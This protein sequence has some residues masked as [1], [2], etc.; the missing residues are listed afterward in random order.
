M[1]LFKKKDLEHPD[2]DWSRNVVLEEGNIDLLF[3]PRANLIYDSVARV[4]S[5]SDVRHVEDS[6]ELSTREILSR[7]ESNG[8]LYKLKLGNGAH[9]HN[10]AMINASLISAQVPDRYKER[11]D[12]SMDA[13]KSIEML[14][15]YNQAVENSK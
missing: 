1:R 6:E 2:S 3:P 14:N 11:A 8:Q 5:G 12:I 4:E 10:K 9:K 13:R 15:A 7:L